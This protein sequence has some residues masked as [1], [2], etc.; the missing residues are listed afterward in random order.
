MPARRLGDSDGTY[1]EAVVLLLP[2]GKK[3]YVK[4]WFQQRSFDCIPMRA[5]L[6]I[7]SDHRT[8][9]R[10][11][12]VTIPDWSARTELPIPKNLAAHVAS[13]VIPGTP[14]FDNTPRA[15]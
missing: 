9:E 2:A 5:G 13:I 11:F 4:K 14:K 8:L 6:L 15:D 7:T 3:A 12:N 10:A 1:V